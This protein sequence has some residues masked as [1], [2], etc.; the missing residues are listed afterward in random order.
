MRRSIASAGQKKGGAAA[1]PWRY[2]LWSWLLEVV[3]GLGGVALHV[4][5][6]LVLGVDC[7]HGALR[8]ARPA[9]DALLGVDHEVVARVVDAVDGTDLD[10]ALVLRADARLSYDV[11]HKSFLLLSLSS[12]FIPACPRPQ[13]PLLTTVIAAHDP[14]HGR[15]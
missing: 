5:G 12:S 7:L 3:G 2:G 15:V 6:D 8:L 11:G 10:A 1:P 9:V 13:H 4:L 14:G